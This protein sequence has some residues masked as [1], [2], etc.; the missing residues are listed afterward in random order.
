MSVTIGGVTASI[1]TAFV[2][3]YGSIALFFIAMALQHHAIIV[4]MKSRLGTRM[5]LHGFSINAYATIEKIDG[6]SMAVPLTTNMFFEQKFP[7]SRVL[8]LLTSVC[9]SLLLVPLISF[10]YYLFILQLD[11]VANAGIAAIYRVSA[12]AGVFTIIATFLYL[13]LFN[14]PIPATKNTR[15]VR[16]GFLYRASLIFPHPNIKKWLSDAESD[17]FFKQKTKR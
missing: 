1:S 16:W 7:I 5:L 9:L 13:L 6:I 10:G 15:H 2:T 3:L 12:A 4:A 14:L 11:I 8:I 17:R